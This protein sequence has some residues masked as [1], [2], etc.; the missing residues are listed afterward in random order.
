MVDQQGGLRRRFTSSVVQRQEPDRAEPCEPEE[1]EAE[2]PK[3]A[4]QARAV[5]IGCSKCRMSRNGCS[6]CRVKAG[7]PPLL[8]RSPSPRKCVLFPLRITSMKSLLQIGRG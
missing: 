7:L 4:G 6:V 5:K 2:A 3:A 1:D 8:K